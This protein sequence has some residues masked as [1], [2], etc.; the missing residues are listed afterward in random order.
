MVDTATFHPEDD[1]LAA[2]LA[3]GLL[4]D[5]ELIGARARFENDADFAAHVAQWQERLA[6][7]TDDI[8]PQA[9]PASVKRAMM[10]RLFPQ[11]RVP[12]WQRLG[13]WQGVSAAAIGAVAVMAVMVLTPLQIPPA[14]GEVYATQM[15]AE[16]SDML[17]LAVYDPDRGDVAINRVAGVAP[18]GRVLELWAII[19]DTP[20]I[21]LGVMPDDPAAR[22]VIPANVAAQ[23]ANITFAVTDEPVGGAPGGVPTGSILAAGAVSSL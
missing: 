9:P 10:A 22:M 20:P 8:A 3:L 7:M 11:T 13:I 23:A 2:E 4:A 6:A 16:G 18:A 14:S 12:F 19:P 17:V 1:L 5:D 15:Q 21:S